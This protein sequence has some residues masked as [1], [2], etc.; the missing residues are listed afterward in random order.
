VGSRRTG[1]YRAV[2]RQSFAAVGAPRIRRRMSI[3]ESAWGGDY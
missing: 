1:G 2:V 3:G